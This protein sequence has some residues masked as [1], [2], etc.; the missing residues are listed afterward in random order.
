MLAWSEQY[1]AL[2]AAVPNVPPHQAQ[3]TICNFRLARISAATSGGM[4]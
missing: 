4:L 3:T 2:P 1:F